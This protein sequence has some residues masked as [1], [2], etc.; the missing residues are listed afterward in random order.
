[1][2]LTSNS[3]QALSIPADVSKRFELYFPRQIVIAGEAD[4]AETVI[5]IN[6]R[7]SSALRFHDMSSSVVGSTA[8]LVLT[9]PTGKGKSEIRKQHPSLLTRG[10]GLYDGVTDAMFVGNSRRKI[11]PE[12][13]VWI[14]RA[15]AS[16]QIEHVFYLGGGAD[17][18][19]GLIDDPKVDEISDP[20][21]CIRA[22]YKDGTGH[23]IPLSEALAQFG[24]TI[25]EVIK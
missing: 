18:I 4:E 14:G 23:E 9:L 6:N 11:R 17:Q 21:D 22:T 3:I 10:A 5:E 24:T 19:D 25:G 13:A 2:S 16:P 15:I 1:M 7:F 20:F 8:T 12:S